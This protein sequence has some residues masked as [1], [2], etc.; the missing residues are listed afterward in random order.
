MALLQTRDM[1]LLQTQDMALLES[2]SL[3]LVACQDI[4]ILHALV[5]EPWPSR[6][7]KQALTFDVRIC[8]SFHALK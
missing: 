5:S 4:N 2:Q 1:A 7:G 3:A 8:L 6:A